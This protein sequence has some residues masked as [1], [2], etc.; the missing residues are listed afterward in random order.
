MFLH[1]LNFSISIIDNEKHKTGCLEIN[2]KFMK[3][4]KQ[5]QRKFCTAGYVAQKQLQVFDKNTHK[6]R[7]VNIDFCALDCLYG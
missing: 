3:Q 2:L 7:N 6:S 4:M 5:N 1:H